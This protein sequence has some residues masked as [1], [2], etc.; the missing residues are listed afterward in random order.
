MNLS[1]RRWPLGI[2]FIVLF[3]ALAAVACSGSDPQTQTPVVISDPPTAV[4]GTTAPQPTV[5]GEQPTQVPT[6]RPTL[7][8]TTAPTSA[9]TPEPTPTNAPQPTPSD[10][11][12]PTPTPTRLPAPTLTPEPTP[13]NTPVPVPTD[14]PEPTV[15]PTPAPTPTPTPVPGPTPAPN[16]IAWTYKISGDG[17]TVNQVDISGDGFKV[18]AGTSA[19][20]VLMLSDQGSLIWTYDGAGDSPAGVT[21]RS[22]TGLGIDVDGNRIAAGFADDPGTETASGAIYLLDDR[23]LKIWSVA[24]EGPISKTGISDDST[25]VVAGSVDRNVYSLN[26]DG[27]T[28][29]KVET[30]TGTGL[31]VNVAAVSSDGTRTVGGDSASQF[32]LLNA[33]GVKIWSFTAD[34]L[35][36]D[37]A[38]SNAGN[39]VAA[40][41][42][43]GSVYIMSSQGLVVGQSKHPETSIVSLSTNAGASRIVAGTAD[44]RVLVFDGQGTMA[45]QTFLGGSVDSVAINTSGSRIAASSGDTVYLLTGDGP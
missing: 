43:N 21:A 26:Q 14:T 33:E 16:Q 31:P 4:S 1:A 9:P 5:D 45:W 30:P 10:T 6:A 3:A 7:S 29:F 34:G 37:V 11:P 2:S 23:P 41:T 12:V 39:R 20:D 22:V 32:Y 27:L 44:G 36:N 25:R 28:R 38:V 15:T 35:V 19:G 24:I 40:G 42:A 8:P 13:T 18:V 17:A